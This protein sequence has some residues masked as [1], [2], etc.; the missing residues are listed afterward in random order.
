M[1]K[2]NVVNALMLTCLTLGVVSLPLFFT[3]AP[4]AIAKPKQP[5]TKTFSNPA[6]DGYPIDVALKGESGDSASARQRGANRFCRIKN[7]T[8]AVG[9]DFT[10]TDEAGESRGT[11][12]WDNANKR[13][14]FCPTCGIYFTRVTCKK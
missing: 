13:W 3:Q 12:Q 7:F 5:A 6:M 4:I 10:S 9:Y 2:F 14:W 8:R 1:R 11:Y